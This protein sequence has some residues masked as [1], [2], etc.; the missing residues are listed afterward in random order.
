[1]VRTIGMH[2]GMVWYSMVVLAVGV[3]CVVYCR[4]RSC[5]CSGFTTRQLQ[6]DHRR[7]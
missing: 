2:H 1:M 6:K 3:T 5:R 4:C 7:T